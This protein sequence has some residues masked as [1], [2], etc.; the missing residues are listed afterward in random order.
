MVQPSETLR[1]PD[2]DQI[3]NTVIASQ[4]RVMAEHILWRFGV[5]EELQTPTLEGVE[6]DASQATYDALSHA[7]VNK[8][9]DGA[10]AERFGIE[11][12]YDAWQQVFGDPDEGA[13]RS[14]E[15]RAK[16]VRNF[17]GYVGKVGLSSW[18]Q[19]ML[20]GHFTETLHDRSQLHTPREALRQRINGIEQKWRNRWL[21]TQVT[22]GEA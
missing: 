22:G 2:L 15:T 11:H 5:T 10:C 20:L 19:M 14:A 3:A 1:T 12:L 9:S 16:G 13:E 18:D 6:K 7:P 4:V 17:V 21:N 8:L